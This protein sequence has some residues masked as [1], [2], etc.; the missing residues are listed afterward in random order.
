MTDILTI[1]NLHFHYP[2]HSFELKLPQLSLKEHSRCFLYGPSGVGKSTLLSLVAGILTPQSGQ[3]LIEG[4]DIT[5]LS[6]AQRDRFRGQHFGLIFQS[7]NLIPYLS[8]EDNIS[9][10]IRVCQRG[11]LSQVQ[12]LIEQLNLTDIRHRLAQNLSLGQQQRV[13]QA[14]ALLGNPKLVIADEPTSSLDEKNAREFMRLLLQQQKEKG[15]ALLFVSHDRRLEEHFE[16]ILSV[17]DFI[18]RRPGP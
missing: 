17:E 12:T 5:Q 3:I 6:P 4:Q 7:F 1:K 10:P 14:R 18:H 13:A 15:L 2:D 8:V 11:N 16:Q 9:L